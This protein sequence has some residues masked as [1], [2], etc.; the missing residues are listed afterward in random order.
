MELDVAIKG[1]DK[2][3]ISSDWIENAINY[4]N[5]KGIFVEFCRL[6]AVKKGLAIFADK[7]KA[8]YIDPSLIFKPKMQKHL[9]EERKKMRKMDIDDQYW[10][11]HEM[12]EDN[13]E[14]LADVFASAFSEIYEKLEKSEKRFASGD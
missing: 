12:D 5:V 1:K 2:D 7:D 6:P 4:I 3:S 11:P 14:K 10:S 13:F 8:G 9:I